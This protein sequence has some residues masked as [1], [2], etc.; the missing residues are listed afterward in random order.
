MQL[1]TVL[2][3]QEPQTNNIQVLG[4]AG[5]DRGGVGTGFNSWDR[6]DKMQESERRGVINF[7]SS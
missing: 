3:L 1:N 4:G 2:L 7:F 6:E 5:V